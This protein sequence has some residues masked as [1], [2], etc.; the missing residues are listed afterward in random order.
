[1][2]AQQ[3]Q[4]WL[5]RKKPVALVDLTMNWR[6][7]QT[8]LPYLQA[9]GAPLSS[10][11]AYAGWNTASNSVGTAVT[12]AAMVLRGKE[13]S[14]PSAASMQQEMDRVAFL[15]ERI[16]DDWYYQKH[17]QHQLNA[18]LRKEKIDPYDLAG[19]SAPTTKRI[20][21]ELSETLPRLIARPW[22]DRFFFTGG[23]SS[24]PFVLY[25][26]Q[27]ETSLPWQRTFEIRLNLFA[28]PAIVHMK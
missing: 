14:L 23:D 18:A 19:Y 22:Q 21:Q 15:A 16:L 25:N 4:D 10:L 2:A 24:R 26:W 13:H 11:I 20:Q 28:A 9:S 17:Y 3:I 6:Q 12:Q 8:L 5:H 1:M 7:E 27:V